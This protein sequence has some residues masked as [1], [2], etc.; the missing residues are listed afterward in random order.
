MHTIEQ[1]IVVGGNAAREAE[2]LSG[3]V[4]ISAPYG[5][6]SASAY[7]ENAE[8]GSGLEIIACAL[9]AVDADASIQRNAVDGPPFN[10]EIV[11]DVCI[12]RLVES[13]Q[14]GVAT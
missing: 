4:I 2:V 1:V 14:G 9:I 10:Q 5:T 6:T 13:V 12:C 8:C 3:V 7:C 11:H